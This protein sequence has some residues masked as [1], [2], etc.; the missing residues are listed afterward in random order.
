MLVNSF[1]VLGLAA[2]ICAC[3]A[4]TSCAANIV[5]G[6]DKTS[7]TLSSGDNELQLRQRGDV[8]YVTWLGPKG[9]TSQ[10]WDAPLV[11]ATFDGATVQPQD[12][13]VESIRTEERADSARLIAKLKHAKL[14]VK[15]EVA[16]VGWSDTGV[17]WEE[18][19]VTNNG[20]AAL[21]VQEI[22]SLAL[23]VPATSAELRYL[24]G[25]KPSERQ[26][27]T[28]P[29]PAKGLTLDN[30]NLG[31]S[32][33]N[34]S[35]WWSLYLPQSDLAYT[36]QLAYSGNWSARFNNDGKVQTAT[37]NETFDNGGPLRLAPGES[38][39]VPSAAITVSRGPDID[40]GATALHQFQRQHVIP[41]QPANDPLLVQY[42]T[43][44]A[45]SGAVDMESV[46]RLIPLAAQIGCEAFVIDANWHRCST[47]SSDWQENLGDWEINRQKFPEGLTPIIKAV[48]DR[49]MKFGIW[50]E[51][52]VASPASD[53]FRSHPE[54]FF[55]LNNK[56]L[57]KSKRLHLDF[58]RPEVRAHMLAV[59][60][61]LMQEGQIDWFKFD[62]NIDV[63]NEFDPAGSDAKNSRLHE[64][65]QGYYQWLD[66]IAKKYPKVILENCASG[67]RR[68]DLGIARY[69]HTAWISDTVN[70]RFSPQV[71]YGALIEFAPETCN[72]WMVGD[73][74]PKRRGGYGATITTTD[75][76]WWDFMFR[77]AM[78]G[79]TGVSSRLDF[80]PPEALKCAQDNISLYKRIRGT[81]HGADVYHL[82]DAPAA[83]PNPTGW[84]GI[85]YNQPLD[86][87]CVALIFRLSLGDPEQPF[88]LKSL[89]PGQNYNVLVDGKPIGTRTGQSL[90]EQG[91]VV[92][93]S[94]EWRGVVIEI[95]PSA[96]GAS[97]L[98]SLPLKISP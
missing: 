49:G 71:A 12:L 25:P 46:G 83:G 86:D 62:Y 19:T 57:V 70:P 59:L 60:D 63:G 77:I 87:S 27:K 8:L 3:A 96:A 51:P 93:L 11:R 30:E 72:H 67:G 64:H 44:Y 53:L 92:E 4:A 39:K 16:W 74:N 41:K 76:A 34:I 81:I 28:V 26:L 45:L 84:M 79:Q 82:T 23:E 35:T 58:S 2:V 90:T 32:T 68:W 91:L 80:W 10:S 24:D 61:R 22:S 9:I 6:E 33:R 36:S 78:N 88:R 47:N 66:D 21:A 50:L 13:R 38:F 85:Q 40:V 37:V 48:H 5:D 31:R 52:E 94:E 14:P 89:K 29:I 55:T 97:V 98:E 54:W 65:L 15:I 69:T 1:R 20:T 7:W 18:I 43:W 95:V 17:F 56:P 42:N 73:I 75:P